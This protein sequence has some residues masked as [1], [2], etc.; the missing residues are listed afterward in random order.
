[1]ERSAPF[2]IASFFDLDAPQRTIQ[3][4]LPIATDPASLR[5]ARKNV[6]LLLSDQLKQQLSRV[7]ELKDM[8]DGKLKRPE[9]LDIGL[10]CSLSIPIITICALFVLFIFIFLLNI[11]FWWVP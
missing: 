2:Q 8:T 5:K 9:P 4:S 7:F 10:V 6:T 1:G 11:V 3:I